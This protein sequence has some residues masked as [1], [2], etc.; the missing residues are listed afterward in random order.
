MNNYAQTYNVLKDSINESRKKID[1]A[2]NGLKL[3]RDEL[4]EIMN[5]ISDKKG[6][7]NHLNYKRN[8]ISS[9]KDKLISIPMTL[10]T[11]LVE[12][13]LVYAGYN[14]VM[15]PQEIIPKI[16]VGLLTFSFGS[17]TCLGI[18]LGSKSIITAMEKRLH[19]KTTKNSVEYQQ[20]SKKIEKEQNNLEKLKK[21]QK[22]IKNKIKILS[23]QLDEERKMIKIDAQRLQRL[24][25]EMI[26]LVLEEEQD[27]L[28]ASKAYARVRTKHNR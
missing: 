25:N 5:K 4:W 1:S 23:S 18:A 8:K 27:N 20:I 19:K 14:I 2:S 16:I 13:G 26:E 22:E 21:D 9:S 15:I 10:L 11:I 6:E 3:L 7:L 12:A 17:C 28:E 24:Q